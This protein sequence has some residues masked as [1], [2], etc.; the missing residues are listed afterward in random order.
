MNAIHHMTLPSGIVAHFPKA[1]D[2][3]VLFV[4]TKEQ[5]T[6]FDYSS[7]SEVGSITLLCEDLLT[8]VAEYVRQAKIAE[9]EKQDPEAILFGELPVMLDCADDYPIPTEEE[10]KQARDEERQRHAHTAAERIREMRA[11]PKTV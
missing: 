3:S 7:Q 9:L 4:F 6:D 10:I 5:V 11:K 2:A 8:L 1:F